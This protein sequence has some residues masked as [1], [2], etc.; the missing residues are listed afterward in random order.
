MALGKNIKSI[1][2]WLVQRK[3]DKSMFHVYATVN[4]NGPFEE[5]EFES[6]CD[7]DG[8]SLDAIWTK[9]KAQ[10]PTVTSVVMTIVEGQVHV[11]E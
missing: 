6:H 10:F 7:I 3:G 11:T 1:G 4:Y 5:E 8:P 9:I 2:N